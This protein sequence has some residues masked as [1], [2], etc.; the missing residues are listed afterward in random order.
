MPNIRYVCLSDLHLGEED[1]LLTEAREFSRPSPVLRALAECL[2]EVL[3]HNERGAA[4]PSLVLAGD[5]LDLALCPEP[6]VLTTFE[7]FL[8]IVMPPNG[9]LFGE[10]IYLPGNHDH[11][12]WQS[13]REAQYLKYLGRLAPGEAMQPPWDATKL[14]MD[15]A[16]KDRLVHDTV[17]AIARRLPHLRE[18]SFEIVTAYPNFGV[19]SGGRAVVFHHGHFIEPAY[20]FLSTAACLIFPE[21]SLPGDVYTLEKENSAWIDFF[22]STMGSCGRIGSDVEGI[23]EASADPDK[24]R[25]LTDTLAESIAAKY[26]QPKWA[27]HFLREWVLK[28]ALHKAAGS[29]SMGLER[30]QAAA[31]TLLSKDAAEGLSWYIGELLT[32]QFRQETGSVPESLAFVF[33]HSHKPFVD[34]RKG[35]RVLNTGGWTIDAPEAQPLHGAAAVLIGDDLTAVSLRC[36]NEGSYD[37]RVEEPVAA[38]AEHSALYRRVEG[39][40]GAQP[41]PWR[42]FGETARA[43]VERRL[44]AF[45]A[46]LSVKAKAAGAGH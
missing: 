10:I 1:S 27:P 6:Q 12:M 14:V 38:G 9:E 33:G 5:V 36:Y 8:R 25:K 26:A 44:A 20:H 24:L 46:R 41:E 4:K 18:R 2:A 32:R 23:Y 13:A 35:V 11:H 39:I 22:W 30:R 15:L 16:E 42:S 3:R 28:A 40:L 31:D 19:R 45:G 43:E 29:L 17:T 34:C 37:M 7:Q 21:Q